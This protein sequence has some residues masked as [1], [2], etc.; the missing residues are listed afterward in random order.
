MDMKAKIRAISS[1][2]SNWFNT[3]GD[4][5]YKYCRLQ[6]DETDAALSSI[7]LFRKYFHLGDY[8]KLPILKDA[9]MGEYLQTKGAYAQTQ[10]PALKIKVAKLAKI[11]GLAYLWSGIEAGRT[12]N[13]PAMLNELISSEFYLNTSYKLNDAD[14][15]TPSFLGNIQMALGQIHGNQELIEKGARMIAL[16]IEVNPPFGLFGAAFGEALAPVHSPVFQQAVERMWTYQDICMQTEVDRSNPDWAPYLP[17]EG[18]QYWNC[19]NTENALH[20]IE[21]YLLNFGDMLLKAGDLESAKTIYKN[22]RYVSTFRDW[23]YKYIVKDRLKNLSKHYEALQS[24][25]P[26]DDPTLAFESK[27]RCVICHEQ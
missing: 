27:Y 21:A 12:K 26:N 4:R 3:R 10:D 17:I 7:E 15:Q 20:R 22:I 23:K 1:K 19:P 11:I 13:G 16:S 8:C 25:D 9:L 24:P 18:G 6:L 14:I 2:S 5:T